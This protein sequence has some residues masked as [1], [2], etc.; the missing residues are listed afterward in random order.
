M[1]SLA[2]FAIIFVVVGGLVTAGP[3]AASPVTPIQ[4]VVIIMQENRSFDSYFGTYPGADGIPTQNGIP[5]VCIPDPRTSICVRPYHDSNDVNAGG[6]HTAQASI[7]DVDGG[8]MNG[9]I[10]QALANCKT[11][12]NRPECTSALPPDVMGYHDGT[13]IPIYWAYANNFVLQDHMFEPVASWSSPAHLYLVS[14]WSA[15][16][17]N[18]PDPMSCH[19]NLNQ[20]DPENQDNSP[21]YAWT[22]ITY[23]L[24]KNGVSWAYYLDNGAQCDKDDGQLC[25]NSKNGVPEIWNPLP[26]FTTVHNDGQLGN[27]QDL[28]NFFAAAKQGTLP[29]VSWVIPNAP[30]SEHPP[31]LVSRGQAYVTNIINAIMQGPNWNSVAIFLAWDDWGGFYDHVVPPNV[32][33]NGYGIRVPGLVISPYAKHG[34]IDHQTLSFDAYLKFIEDLFLTGQRLDPNNDGRP[35]PRPEVRENAGQLGDLSQDFDFSQPP[36]APF[37]V[38]QSPKSGSIST[39]TRTVTTATT[40]DGVLSVLTSLPGF[41]WESIALGL[42]FGALALVVMRRKKTTHTFAP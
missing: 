13:D 3:V 41:P 18:P 32:D 36:R 42:T 25:Q 2:M 10:Q 1:K 21:D 9:F 29:A 27:L 40:Q 33:Q 5:T 17:N 12:P 7:I 14:A 20:P 34:Y 26:D 16:C 4:H 8:K 6:P 39:L 15:S 28:S 22:D 30:D 31:A 38:P 23:L 37:M 24:A 11:H 35:D 19:S